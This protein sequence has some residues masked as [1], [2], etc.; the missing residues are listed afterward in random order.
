MA[1]LVQGVGLYNNVL[2]RGGL[3][4]AISLAGTAGQVLYLDGGMTVFHNAPGPAGLLY[5]WFGL[6]P[7]SIQEQ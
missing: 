5:P 4:K 7:D 6:H 1:S 3:E 2:H